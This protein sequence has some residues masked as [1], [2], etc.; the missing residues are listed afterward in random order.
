[1]LFGYKV[2]IMDTKSSRSI[3]VGE[4]ERSFTEGKLQE[5]PT[6]QDMPISSEDKLNFAMEFY[7]EVPQVI[8]LETGHNK[9]KANLCQN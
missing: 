3:S 8:F 2:P 7:I 6:E 1:M 9:D 5:H 4:N